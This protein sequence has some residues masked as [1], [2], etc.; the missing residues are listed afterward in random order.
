MFLPY[1]HQ[2]VEVNTHIGV[3]PN[4]QYLFFE[5]QFGPMLAAFSQ[6]C[7]CL[8]VFVPEDFVQASSEEHQAFVRRNLKGY[9]LARTPIEAADETVGL[10]AFFDQGQVCRILLL[11]TPFQLLVWQLLIQQ[12]DPQ[13]VAYSELATQLG[14]SSSVRAVASAVAANRI[15]L[16]IACHRVVQKDR[17]VGA[18][19]W[20]SNLKR[21]I[22]AAEGF[23]A[24][25]QFSDGYKSLFGDC[26][27]KSDS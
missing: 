27:V 17:G 4:V 15:A 9:V 8:L 25:R 12:A 10:A 18:Y 20:G 13:V 26:L 2:Q 21:N 5:S 24:Y 1:Q 11:G 23:E 16:Y 22:L 3:L 14:K 6:A 7:L 19:R